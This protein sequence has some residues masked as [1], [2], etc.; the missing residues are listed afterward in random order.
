[1][2]AMGAFCEFME[3]YAA[4]LEEV[5]AQ[6]GTKYS[7]L[8]SYD[9]QRMD[10]AISQQQA[11]LMKLEQREKQRIELQKRAGFGEKSFREILDCADEPWKGRLEDSFKRVEKAIQE[12]KF[13]NEKSMSLARLNL[14]IVGGQPGEGAD[15]IHHTYAP[16]KNTQSAAGGSL[17]ETKI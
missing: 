13:Y 5:Q 10:Q 15:G 9:L 6:E 1:M 14:Q 3:S 7:A 4:F 8:V 16:G 11:L 12:I 2:E 17:F